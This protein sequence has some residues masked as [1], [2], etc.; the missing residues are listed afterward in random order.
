MAQGEGVW[1]MVAGGMACHDPWYGVSRVV[2][3]L[4]VGILNPNAL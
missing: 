1:C 4:G 3:G 2:Q